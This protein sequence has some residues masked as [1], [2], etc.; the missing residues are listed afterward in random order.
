MS[1]IFELHTDSK[2][3]ENIKPEWN[4]LLVNSNSDN[5]FLT[6]EWVKTWWEIY[7]KNYKLFLITIRDANGKL[8]A[9]A[10][11]KVANRN[12]IFGKVSILG[13]IGCGEKVTPELL[14]LLISS[15]YS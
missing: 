9:I 7:G 14:S 4:N 5:I 3:F 12:M 13:F 1:L 6:W 2:I 10:P 11:L 8:L 15:E